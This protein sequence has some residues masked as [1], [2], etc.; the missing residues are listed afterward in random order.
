MPLDPFGPLRVRHPVPGDGAFSEPPD[1]TA[2]PLAN[3]RQ[4]LLYMQERQRVYL[5]RQAGKP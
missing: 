4:I 1:G 2:F 5:A 3:L